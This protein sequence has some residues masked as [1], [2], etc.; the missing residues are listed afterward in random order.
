MKESRQL[1]ERALELR[2]LV[3]RSTALPALDDATFAHI[4]A[5]LELANE[6]AEQGRQCLAEEAASAAAAE[7]RFLAAKSSSEATPPMLTMASIAAIALPL[8]VVSMS[9]ALAAGPAV[10]VDIAPHLG[11]SSARRRVRATLRR[12]AMGRFG[13]VLRE[14]DGGVYIAKLLESDDMADDERGVLLEGDYVCSLDGAAVRTPHG[15][16][17]AS[18][19]SPDAAGVT[20]AALDAAAAPPSSSAP[21]TLEEAKARLRDAAEGITIEVWRETIRPVGER[22]GELNT[23]V[24]SEVGRLGTAVSNMAKPHLERAG[25][26]VDKLRAMIDRDSD[27]RRV[28]SSR[29]LHEQP[30][31]TGEG[32]VRASATQ[33]HSSV[34]ATTPLSTPLLIDL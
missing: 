12:D 21:L 23:Q 22:L 16:V 18:E 29:V 3:L 19:T 17:A 9:A 14:D 24:T 2:K 13:V 1:R 8:G 4:V 10:G 28:V 26:E 25:M 32:A 6:R 34:A 7:G 11:L 15:T 33:D 20:A 30:T 31:S 27:S 5:Q